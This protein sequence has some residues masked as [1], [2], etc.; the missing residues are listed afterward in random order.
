MRLLFLLCVILLCVR[1]Y[2]AQQ[3]GFGDSEALYASYAV[4]PQA[5]Y[6]D[7]P[8]LVGLVARVIGGGTAPAPQQAHLFTAFVSS[9]VPLLVAW[10]AR[11]AGASPRA[12]VVAGAIVAVTPEI[13]IGLF[14]LTP[15]LLLAPLW[16]GAIGLALFGVTKPAVPEPPPADTRKKKPPGT[17]NKKPPPAPLPKD[18]SRRHGALAFAGILAGLSASA[19]VSGLLL[20]AALVYSFVVLRIRVLWAWLGLLAGLL[21]FAP[22]VLFEA[23]HGFPMVRHRLFEAP[24]V[25][26]TSGVSLVLRNVGTLLGGQLAYLS[27]ILAVV[28]VIVA[29]DLFRER[30]RDAATRV[31]FATFAIPI[32][33]LLFLCLWSPVAEPHW[34]APPLLTLPIHAARRA[35]QIRGI[36]QRVLIAGGGLAA[37]LTAI[38]HAWILVPSFATLLPASFDPK[39]DITNEL[40]G[41]PAAI[42]SVRAAMLETATP[43]DPMGHDVIV[44]GPHWIVCAQLQAAMPDVR[45]GCATPIKDDFDGWVPREKWR[46]A[47]KVLYVTDN[48]FPGNGASELP[49]H[50][51]ASEHTTRVYRAGRP[52]RTFAFYLYTRQA[53]GAL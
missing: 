1:L 3:V 44:V 23:T 19:K 28:A 42:K 39:L 8:G 43:F 6:L 14:G 53:V 9:V 38:V 13:A 11:V 32:V 37:V 26:T 35:G 20:V 18:E 34:L 41:W 17:K 27:P 36:G 30:N 50:V 7:H 48:R 24:S 47:D 22:V 5:A 29:R 4:H 15:D 10:A 49:G 31:L 45:V 16:L 51:V 21:V 25:V 46:A 33:P 52:A 2:A 40:Y 12:A